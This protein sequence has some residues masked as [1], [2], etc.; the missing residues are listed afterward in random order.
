M[1]VSSIPTSVTPPVATAAPSKP[2][3]GPVQQAS[4]P[5][6]QPVAKAAGDSDGDHD[7]STGG[8][9]NVKA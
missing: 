2:Q 8:R 5:A 6:A 3:A 7:G 9:I 4:P 1:N